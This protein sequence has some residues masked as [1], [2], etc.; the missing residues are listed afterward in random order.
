MGTGMTYRLLETMAGLADKLGKTEDAAE[1]RAAM[2]KNTLPLTRNFTTGRNRFTRQPP[3]MEV[4]RN[5]TV[6]S[7]ARLHS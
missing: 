2:E 1:Y 4:T 3:G 7:T 6:P 5:S